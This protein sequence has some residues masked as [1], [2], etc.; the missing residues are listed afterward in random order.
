MRTGFGWPTSSIEAYSRSLADTTLRGLRGQSLGAGRL[1]LRCLVRWNRI[2]GQ[3][4][5][6][7]SVGLLFVSPLP[8]LSFIYL[9]LGSAK[10]S[11]LLVG[12][13][14]FT[15]GES[16]RGVQLADLMLIHLKNE[17][18]KP[19]ESTPCMCSTMR[20]GKLNQHGK[21]E[22][23]GCMWNANPVLCLLS[24]LAFYFFFRWGRDGVEEFPSFR[25]P[26]D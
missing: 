11:P 12:H 21:V 26:E 24:A 19:D 13:T 25:Q 16:R 1:P 8:S 20:Q 15:P 2:Y 23:M 18:P 4:P 22:Y 10:S 9:L 7:C 5:T 17:V 14:T 3:Q 6:T